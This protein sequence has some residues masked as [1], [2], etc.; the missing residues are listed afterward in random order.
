MYLNDVE[1]CSKKKIR[2]DEVNTNN[3]DIIQTNNTSF[4]VS[5]K[6]EVHK[7]K[8]ICQIVKKNNELD[9]GIYTF[10]LFKKILSYSK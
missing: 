6:K 10:Y 7:L 5:P 9:C 1:N 8:Q 4:K 3:T 2:A